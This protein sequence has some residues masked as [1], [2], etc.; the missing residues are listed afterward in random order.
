[1]AKIENRWHRTQGRQTPRNPVLRGSDGIDRIGFESIGEAVIDALADYAQNEGNRENMVGKWAHYGSGSD[2]WGNNQTPE[3][4]L[5]AI[6][7]PPPELLAA[8]DEMRRQLVDEISPP[9]CTRRRIRRNQDIGDE[10]VPEQVL[11]R[12]IT[13]W[14]R[15]VR[16]TQPRRSVTIGVNLSVNA[17]RRAHDLLWRGAAAAA[18]ADVLTERGVNVEIVAFWSVVGMSSRSEEVVS[19]YVIKRADMPLDVGAVSVA[20]AEIGFARLIALFGLCRHMPG[21]L[22][23]RLGLPVDLPARDRA[24]I[25][26]LAEKEIISREAAEDWLRRSAARQE[27]E[28][29]H[30]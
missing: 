16:E 9:T 8:V 6:S 23:D 24:G 19:R 20:L 29:C 22:D 2:A 27:S 5:A 10:L 17:N 21:L 30:V 7:N 28:V 13:P 18:L 12:S 4:L 1:M 25:D 3:T 14:Q 15:S 11:V 26:Y